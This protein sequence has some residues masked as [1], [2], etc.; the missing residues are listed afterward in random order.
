MLPGSARGA[1]SASASF[2]GCW[3]LVVGKTTPRYAPGKLGNPPLS[4]FHVKQAKFWVRG[5]EAPMHSGDEVVL[6]RHRR[7]RTRRPDLSLSVEAGFDAATSIMEYCPTNSSAWEKGP[8][9]GNQGS[10]ASSMSV[11][12]AESRAA[13]PGGLCTPVYVREEPR[14]NRGRSL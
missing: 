2:I 9:I 3:T 14:R 12:T 5:N 4:V 6:A 7:D 11:E 8:P 13:V 10:I 1:V